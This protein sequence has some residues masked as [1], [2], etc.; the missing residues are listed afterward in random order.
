MP[1]MTTSSG[2][3]LV[4]KVAASLQ[5][6]EFVWWQWHNHGVCGVRTCGTDASEYSRG[7]GRHFVAGECNG[8]DGGKMPT[9]R[10]ETGGLARTISASR[11][12]GEI[13][14]FPRYT[15]RVSSR[16]SMAAPDSWRRPMVELSG[17]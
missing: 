16:M 5:T 6:V 8:G 10:Q 15:K 2:D 9:A 7:Y 3:S 4:G 11:T 1:T 13:S 14:R 12:T 17:I